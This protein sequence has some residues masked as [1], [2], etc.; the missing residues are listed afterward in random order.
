LITAA[1]VVRKQSSG[2]RAV[3]V[4]Y[5]AALTVVAVGWAGT[6]TIS[7]RFS[8]TDWAQFNDRRGA[9]LDAIDIARRFPAAG[10]GLNTYGTATLFYQTHH[11]THHYSQAHNDYLQLAAEGGVL[12]VLPAI[13]CVV[14][15]VAAVRRRFAEE[16]SVGTYWLRLGA[17]TALAAMALQETVDFSLQMPGNAILFTVVCAIALHSTPTRQR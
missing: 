4:V 16:S 15:F 13:A 17:C 10:S 11:L 14:F 9:W 2:R 7:A 8:Q 3:S 12:L 5:L 6:D 1:F